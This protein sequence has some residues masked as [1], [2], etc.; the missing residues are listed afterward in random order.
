LLHKFHKVKE[1]GLKEH[2]LTQNAE[3]CEPTTCLNQDFRIWSMRRMILF[4]LQKE[5]VTILCYKL[6]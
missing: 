6:G 5:Y 4:V 2:E 3:L 1:N